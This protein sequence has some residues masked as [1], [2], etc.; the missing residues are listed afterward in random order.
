MEILQGFKIREGCADVTLYSRGLTT[1]ARK[2]EE[3]STIFVGWL[4]LAQ[5][6]NTAGPSSKNG[7]SLFAILQ[8]F[9]KLFFSFFFSVSQI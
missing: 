5:T 2:T 9:R 1:S 8:D 6:L 7:S 3:N 4:A